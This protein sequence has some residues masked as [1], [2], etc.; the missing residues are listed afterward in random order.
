VI[1]SYF[2][3]LHNPCYV[4]IIAI[5]PVLM[6]GVRSVD[7]VRCLRCLKNAIKGG[8]VGFGREALPLGK[9]SV[10]PALTRL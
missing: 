10:R 7:N 6:H 4:S 3:G 9:V 8:K 1:A 5:A 2:R